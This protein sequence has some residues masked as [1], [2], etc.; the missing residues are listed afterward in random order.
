[1][2]LALN[3]PTLGLLY[4]PQMSPPEAVRFWAAAFC[5]S[6]SGWK[7]PFESVQFRVV[8]KFAVGPNCPA[9]ADDSPAT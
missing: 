6:Q 7:F 5:R 2:V 4:G 9:V 3:V 1:M 8:L